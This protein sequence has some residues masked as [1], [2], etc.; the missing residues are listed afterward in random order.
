MY[1]LYESAEEGDSFIANIWE[2]LMQYKNLVEGFAYKILALSLSK[3]ISASVV[4]DISSLRF[5]A[6][7]S[8]LSATLV[9]YLPLLLRMLNL[10]LVFSKVK[11]ADST[12]V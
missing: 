3:D 7:S 1:T 2:T 5:T 6:L 9:T 10:P 12:F 11:S 4:S 8:F